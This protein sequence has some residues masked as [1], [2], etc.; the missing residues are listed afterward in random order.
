MS[1]LIVGE[2]RHDVKF[3]VFIRNNFFVFDIEFGSDVF[4]NFINVELTCISNG[5]NQEF[6]QLQRG[7]YTY[8]DPSHM[9][10]FKTH[11]WYKL[12]A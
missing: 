5:M 10:Y 6:K 4:N 2:N 9:E 11:S 1:Y 8:S 12:P 7:F 3:V